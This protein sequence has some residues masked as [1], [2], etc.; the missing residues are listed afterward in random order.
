V[1]LKAPAG[2][3]RPDAHRT[4]CDSADRRDQRHYWWLHRGGGKDRDPR[5]ALAKVSF[6]LVGEQNPNKVRDAFRAFVK[7]RLPVDCKAE[8]GKLCRC[9]GDRALLR[10][11]GSGQGTHRSGSRMGHQGG[12]HRRR[13]LH[14]N[15]RRLQEHLGDG[16]RY[17]S[18]FALDDDRGTF[19][20]REVRLKCYHK[21]IRSWARILRGAGGLNRRRR[22]QEAMRWLRRPG[23]KPGRSSMAIGNEGNVAIMGIRTHAACWVPPYSMAHGSSRA[24][25]PDL[26][27]I[28]HG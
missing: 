21:G 5:T 27:F 19:A 1:G 22:L 11:S 2:R 26:D 23:R 7:A 25:A 18:A 28:A 15:R 20:Q 13:R 16:F 10:Q 12:H 4:N 6:R 3:K 14:P 9:A 24:S 8:F 17:W